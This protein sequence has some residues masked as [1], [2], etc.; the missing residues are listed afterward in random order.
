[1]LRQVFHIICQH[2]N[3]DLLKWMYAE[4]V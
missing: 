4:A 2:N 1:M 3:A